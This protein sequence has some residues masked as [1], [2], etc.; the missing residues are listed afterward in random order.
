[1][2]EQPVYYEL[3]YVSGVLGTEMILNSITPS[4]SI[5]FIFVET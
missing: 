5:F 1:M 2:L 3:L 4:T